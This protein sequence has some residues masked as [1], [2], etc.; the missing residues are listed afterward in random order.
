MGRFAN[1]PCGL[2]IELFLL[3][4]VVAENLFEGL[5]IPGG[6][7][8]SGIAQWRAGYH[9]HIIGNAQ[10]FL[11]LRLVEPTNPAGAQSTFRCNQHRV[12]AQEGAS[13][14]ASMIYLISSSGT[15]SGLYRRML[16]RFLITSMN[17]IVAP[18][19]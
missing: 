8:F 4:A 16:L 10:G 12:V 6:R 1:R 9:A 14:A 18:P 11:H 3:V 13:R 15:G 17:S 5:P 19:R 2:Q 7:V